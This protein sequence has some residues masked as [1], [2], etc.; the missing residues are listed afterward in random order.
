MLL[1]DET[2]DAVR[3]VF[4]DMRKRA[5][6]RF[7]LM[8]LGHDPVLTFIADM[9]FVGQAFEV[10]VEIDTATLD[11]LSAD[12]LRRMFS[13]EHH[14]VFMH[15][16]DAANPIEIVSFRLGVAAPLEHIPA[17]TEDRSEDAGEEIA[18]TMFEHGEQRAGRAG[19]RALLK[20]GQTIEGPWL[21]E[22]STSTICVPA[23][24]SAELD[25]NQNLVLRRV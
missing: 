11:R 1:A 16:G 15:G 17:L 14:R 20:V 10:G 6:E 21:M 4:E 25:A 7:V 24:W 13:E 18:W 12:D 8:G 22:D 5:V 2:P 19:S 23:G 3:E 9:R